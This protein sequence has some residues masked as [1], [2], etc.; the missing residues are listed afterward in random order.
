MTR[1]E[2]HAAGFTRTINLITTVL[3]AVRCAWIFAAP[4]RSGDLPLRFAQDDFFYYLKP[5]QNLAWFHRST[6]DGSTLTNGYHPLYFALCV[7]M[8]F[9]ARTI[10]AIFRSLWVVDTVSATAIFL[11]TRRLFSRINSAVLSN[12]FAI[13][14]TI[15]CVPLICDQMEI[16]LALPLGFAFLLTGFVHGRELTVRRAAALGILGALTFLA[17]LDAGILVALYATGTLCTQEYRRALT[18]KCVASFLGAGLPLPLLYF[19]INEHFFG[20]LL[21]ISGRAK[22]LRHSWKPSILLPASFNGISELLLN[23]ALIT[24]ILAWA[25]RKHLRPREKVFLFAVLATPFLFYFLE[26]LVSDW[27]IWNWYFYDLRFAASGG[28]MLAGILLSRHILTLEF[29]RL[30][31]LLESDKIAFAFEGIALL[32]LFLMHYKID[33]WMVEIQHAAETLTRFEREHPGKYA[34]GD[35]AGMFATLAS[36][37]VLQTEGL[38][39]DQAYL[40]HIRAQDDLRSVLASYGVNY[41]VMFVF[42][43]NY[44]WQLH[45]GCVEAL[46]PSIAGP[47]SYRIRSDFC[48]API[49]QF[50]GM[51][52]RYLIYRI[53]PT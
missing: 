4:L 13:T 22:Q 30:Q 21:P 31:A 2:Q 6:F 8:S 20:T 7:G 52:G 35:R 46:E 3:V 17:R 36:S 34:M 18:P 40:R 27:P 11:L 29:P 25:L 10:P 42:E 50:D 48:E 53:N 39:M 45:H 24:A 15:L 16:T 23:V 51:D 47:D 43:R 38:V 9:F 28:L 26:M 33:H 32:V 19:W 49:Y 5:A 14:V 41:Y 1:N 44:P 37:P 12:A